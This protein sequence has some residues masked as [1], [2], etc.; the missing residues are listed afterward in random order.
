MYATPRADELPAWHPVAGECHD[1]ADA[2]VAAHPGDTLLRGWLYQ[3]LDRLPEGLMHV[4]VA[5]SVVRT[6]D[7]ALIDVTLR[8][9][10]PTGRFL[11]HPDDVGGFFGFLLNPASP[12]EFKVLEAWPGVGK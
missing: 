11:Q 3:R 6:R 8:S 2:W 4:F 12:T 5:H 1:N 10:E 7:G 9:L